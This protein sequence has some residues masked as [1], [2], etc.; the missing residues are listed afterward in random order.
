[1]AAMAAERGWAH[2]AYLFTV[3]TKAALGL[4]Q[5]AG[6]VALLISPA[7]AIQRW[8]EWLTQSELG[9]TPTDRLAGLLTAWARD[10]PVGA[11]TFY[12]TYLFGHGVLNFGVAMLMLSGARTPIVLSI[13]VLAG[14]CVF[15]TYE[16]YHSQ[17]AALIVLTA[18]DLIVI[19]LAW[20]EL[21]RKKVTG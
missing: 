6:W 12:Q 17:D 15:Q 9:D 8:V 13:V 19:W 2:V 5:L 21:R 7:G 11:E 10:L 14:F 16:Y 20:L 1:M 3:W 18:I 4:A